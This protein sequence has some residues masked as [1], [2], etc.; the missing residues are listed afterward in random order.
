MSAEIKP[1][2]SVIITTVGGKPFLQKC[3]IRLVSQT[4]GRDIEVIVPYDSTAREI[5]ELKNIFS[6]VLFVDMG[7]VKTEG[8]PGTQQ[9]A[10][11]MFDRRT[12]AGLNAARGE[13]LA[14][15]QDYGSPD[16]SWCDQL[17]EAHRLPYDV[18][19]P[20]PSNM[21]ERDLD[22][23]F[24]SRLWAVNNSVLKALRLSLT[25]PFSTNAR[26]SSRCGIFGRKV[27][28]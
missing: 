27:E 11:E 28:D 20:R 24:F 25:S 6:Q 22:W 7:V 16:P 9:A 1:I 4:A 10:H 17:L 14:L 15:L 18:I 12:A 26:R 13:I 19:G 23:A 8:R 21:G 2:L 5:A 3:L